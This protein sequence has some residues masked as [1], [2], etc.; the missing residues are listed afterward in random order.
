MKDIVFSRSDGISVTYKTT[1]NNPDNYG[2][3]FTIMDI[4]GIN[5]FLERKLFA[6]FDKKVWTLAEML[7]FACNNDMTVTIYNGAT[8]IKTCQCPLVIPQ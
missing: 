4:R 6:G 2:E 8:L 1:L 7:F 3:N 5:T